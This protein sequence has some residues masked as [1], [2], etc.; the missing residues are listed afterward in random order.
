MA[1][2]RTMGWQYHQR[3]LVAT[4]ATEYPNDTAWQRFL[5]TGPL[6]LLPVRSGYSNIVWSCSP[7]MAKRLESYSSK[8]FADAVN[9]V[10]Q[11]DPSTINSSG[12]S[13]NST[14]LAV[15]AVDAAVSAAETVLQQL[16]GSIGS[17][18]LRQVLSPGSMGSASA[19]GMG[20]G[21]TAY[22]YSGSGSAAAAA[23][24]GAQW[25]RPPV[26]EGWVGTSPKSF[27]L[28]LKHSGR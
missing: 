3:G 8:Q 17:T 4:V 7:D 22:G 2:F 16:G 25:R 14:G 27:P 9:E 20:S 5:P 1:G 26:V 28:Q 6:A 11:V 15:P 18:M 10:L 13:S 23:G 19:S 12:S 21:L 24:G